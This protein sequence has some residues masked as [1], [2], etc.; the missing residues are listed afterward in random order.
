M[1]V[2][3]VSFGGMWDTPILLS[4]TSAH[5]WCR[6]QN[7]ISGY[8][9]DALA[10]QYLVPCGTVAPVDPME[11][12]IS[13]LGALDERV[14]AFEFA[15]HDGQIICGVGVGLERRLPSVECIHLPVP[16]IDSCPDVRRQPTNV[17]DSHLR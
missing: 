10:I 2:V 1:V 6:L 14:A 13:K 7:N 17:R 11:D 12:F 15:E 4:V 16:L 5:P 8:G 3:V 9:E